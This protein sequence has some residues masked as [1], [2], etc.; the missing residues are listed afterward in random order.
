ML[1]TWGEFPTLQ[2]QRQEVRYPDGWWEA[3]KERW[4]PRWAL[5]R[6]PVIYVVRVFDS[7][8]V[9]PHAEDLRHTKLGASYPVLVCDIHVEPGN[10]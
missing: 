3:L 8:R 9:F 7:R 5:S 6:W 2:L 1:H 10:E 4:F